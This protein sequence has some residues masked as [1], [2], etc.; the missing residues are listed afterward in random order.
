MVGAR[1]DGQKKELIALQ[2]G[3]RE[4]EESWAELLRDLK[5]RGMQAPAL[6]IG[7]GAL[8]FWAAVRDVF[9]QTRHQRDWVHKTANVLDALPKSARIEGPRRPLRR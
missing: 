6:A 3:Y 2:D 7:D 1:I 8:G 9:P 4:S 5:K